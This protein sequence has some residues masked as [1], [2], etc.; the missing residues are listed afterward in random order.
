MPVVPGF[1][2]QIESQNQIESTVEDIGYP[3]IVKASAGGGGKEMRVVNKKVNYG[4][5]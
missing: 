2:G 5:Q 1:A 4:I 3:V